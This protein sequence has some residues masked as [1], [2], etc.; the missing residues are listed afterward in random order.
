MGNSYK[1]SI[2]LLGIFLPAVLLSA[3]LIFAI[4]KMKSI[5]TTLKSKEAEFE[6]CKIAEVA[7]QQR[8]KSVG[9]NSEQ[10]EFWKDLINR[11]TRGTVADHLS[12]AQSQSRAQD[13]K[14]ISHNWIN[15][16]EGIGSNTNQPAG[17]LKMTFVAT[18]RAMQLTMLDFE[19]TLPQMQ[20][21]S[22]NMKAID[23]SNLIQFDTLFTLWTK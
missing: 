23:K 4:V 5:N 2:L 9:I 15:L 20:L 19:T 1:K 18:Y 11:E 16:S 3:V 14:K 6:Q 10:L 8:Q 17:Q 13:I 21:D 22:I 7:I 12:K